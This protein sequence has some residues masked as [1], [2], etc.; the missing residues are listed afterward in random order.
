MSPLP[1]RSRSEIQSSE[2]EIEQRFDE[3]VEVWPGMWKEAILP[4]KHPPPL[5][6]L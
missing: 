1:H 3:A 2:I 5:M 4:Y 6:M